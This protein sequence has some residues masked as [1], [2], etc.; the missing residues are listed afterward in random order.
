M[1][2]LIFDGHNDVLSKLAGAGGKAAAARFET[3]LNGHLDLP[4]ARSGGFGGGF[5]AMWARTPGMA[6]GQLP[7]P[8]PPYDIAMPPRLPRR[9][10]WQQIRAQ[11]DLLH[12]LHARGALRIC[13]SVGEIEQARAD[14][15]LAAI[16]HLE[17]AEG[18]GPDLE[19]LEQ[20]YA[21][22]L[23]SLGPVWSRPNAFGHGVPFRYPSDGDIGG[24]LSGRGRALV[25]RC[26]D[27][28]ILVDL[29]HL[30]MA[31]IRE[32]AAL[33]DAP[34]VATHSNA[35]ALCPHS[36]NLTDDQLGLIAASGGLVGLNFQSCFLRPDGASDPD[37]PAA[38]PLAHLDH[39]LNIL[40]EE[41]VGIGS[42]YD[43]CMP[44]GWLASVD[45][46]PALVA[47][48][49][50]HGYGA[51]RIERICWGNWMRVLRETWGG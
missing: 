41:G 8:I 26:A 44:P 4:R 38:V 2:T 25:E 36:R 43:G 16:L 31:G 32:V 50:R 45:R 27:L 28:R 21:L 46:L 6:G 47:A 14:A 51:D 22:G 34:L 12:D 49:D 5:F 18:I 10:A 1:T 35:H 40:G 7:G 20:L 39:L 37:I 23:R 3:G 15:Q 24:G 19:H 9:E 29:S 17:G 30:N 48:M 42:D 13:T 11:A 33:S